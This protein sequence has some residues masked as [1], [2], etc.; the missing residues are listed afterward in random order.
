M[1][2]MIKMIRKKLKSSSGVSILMG[3]LML[4]VAAM[5]SAVLI[6][7]SLTTAMAVRTDYDDQQAYLTVSSAARL[8]ESCLHGKKATK[9]VTT[10]YADEEKTIISSE[11]E[12]EWTANGSFKGL[13]EAAVKQVDST[14]AAYYYPK[15]IVINAGSGDD[16]L[17]EVRMTFAMGEDYG[18]TATFTMAESSSRNTPF[19]VLKLTAESKEVSSG[20]TKTSIITWTATSLD[21]VRT[22]Y[23]E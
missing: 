19:L 22:S 16:E 11:T 18:I 7:A 3:L 21:T 20:D 12:K 1:Q 10:S 2:I 6:A 4:L 17:E 8:V 5:V 23:D 14:K 13:L 15:D 9:I